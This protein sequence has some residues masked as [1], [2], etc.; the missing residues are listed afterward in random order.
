MAA[1]RLTIRDIS[2]RDVFP[3]LIVFRT[4]GL[5]SSLP[6]LFLATLGAVLTPLGWWVS[7][8]CFVP[9]AAND[10]D[11]AFA[12]VLEANR[13]GPHRPFPPLAPNDGRIPTSVR[14]VLTTQPDIVQPIFHR[15]VTPVARLFDTRLTMA[16]AGYYAVGTLWTLLIWG[17]YGGAITRMAV[18]K[19]GREEQISLGEALSHA[20]QKLLSYMFS[21]LFPLLGVVL[22]GLPVYLLGLLMRLDAGVLIAGLAWLFVLLGGLAMAILL[23]GALFGWPLMWGVISSEQHGDAFEA[24]SRSFSYTFG[25]PLHYLFYVVLAIVF[26]SLSW[27]VVYHISELVIVAGRLP[28]AW[29]AGPERWQAVLRVVEAPVADGAFSVSWPEIGGWLIGSFESVV[30]TIATAFGYSFFWCQ[31]AAVYLLLR[32]DVDQTEFDEVFVEREDRRYELPELKPVAAI[33][34]GGAT[35]EPPASSDGTAEQSGP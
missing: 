23:I 12:Q 10:A 31:A 30:R 9:S 5:A 1:E 7:E 34:P 21:P 4:F 26:G 3:W 6:V 32:R 8:Q 27:L 13:S 25:R 20:R 22:I 33:S 11:T 35:E 16:Q 17:F 29:G 2:W 14:D 19:L 28:A 24:F 18:V 15:F